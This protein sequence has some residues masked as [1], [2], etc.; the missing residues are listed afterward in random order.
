MSPSDF[1]YSAAQVRQLDRIAI[2]EHGVPAIVL[3]KRAG[4]A[5]FNCLLEKWPDITAIHIVCGSGNNGGDGYI[6][7]A[8]ALQRGL[9]ATV[10]QLSD[11]LSET[12]DRAKSYAQQEGV[13]IHPFDAEKLAA[14]M[15]AEPEQ[16][17]LVDALLGTGV[18]GDLHPAW[19]EAVT[20]MNHSSWPVLSLDIPSGVNPDNG[21]VASTSVKAQATI[22][23]IGQKLGGDITF[24]KR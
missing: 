4:R 8:L 11:R 2:E 14:V 15:T 9:S 12:A 16:G 20:L 18:K 10:W 24:S 23:F 19:V 3:M 1:L 13:S 5:A 17:V 21:V 6:V 22:S 7:A